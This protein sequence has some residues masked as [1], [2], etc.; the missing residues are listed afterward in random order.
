MTYRSSSELADLVASKHDE[1]AD[2]VRREA[3]LAISSVRTTPEIPG[4]VLLAVEAAMAAASREEPAPPA[5][6]AVAEWL[7]EISS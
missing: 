1:G 7:R 3:F 2:A 6:R 5:V 4:P